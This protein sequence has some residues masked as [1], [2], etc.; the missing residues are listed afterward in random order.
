MIILVSALAFWI[1][2]RTLAWGFKSS[3]ISYKKV[4]STT[5]ANLSKAGL[6]FLVVTI[7]GSLGDVVFFSVLE[8][9]SVLFGSPCSSFSFVLSVL[10]LISVLCLLSLHCKFLLQY[11]RLKPKLHADLLEA[12]EI[13]IKKHESMKALY[14]DFSDAT[15]FKHGFMLV[16]VTRDIIVGLVITTMS[17]FPLAE[18]IIICS[19]SVLMCSYLLLNNPFRH[20]SNQILQIF[21]ELSVLVA[22]ICTLSL[23]ISDVNKR[24]MPNNRERLGM[25]IICIN[26]ILN[27]GCS[28]LLLFKIAQMVREAYNNYSE[29]RTRK[30]HAVSIASL[31]AEKSHNQVLSRPDGVE[32]FPNSS[33]PVQNATETM[34]DIDLHGIQQEKINRSQ[35][36]EESNCNK[37]LGNNNETVWLESECSLIPSKI[38]N[39]SMVSPEPILRIDIKPKADDATTQENCLKLEQGINSSSSYSFNL[40]QEHRKRNLR[41]DLNSFRHKPISRLGFNQERE[42]TEVN[43]RHSDYRNMKKLIEFLKSAKNSRNP[44]PQ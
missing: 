4:I 17:S 18:A 6:N 10:F 32:P 41:I 15:L 11:R 2:C 25:A 23:A 5:F 12:F 13:F 39:S 14:D 22:F 44:T 20:R 21:A 16:L 27:S 37:T 28:I 30:V 3:S 33:L 19:C 40:S 8:M 31:S 34:H 9:K 35:F 1:A 7:Y 43:D 24:V 29:K 42:H 38:R 36:L 26:V